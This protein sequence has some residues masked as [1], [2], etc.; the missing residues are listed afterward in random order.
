MI[1][2]LRMENTIEDKLIGSSLER[3]VPNVVRD[4]QRIETDRSGERPQ[5][6]GEQ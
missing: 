3:T 2:L 6:T 5:D 1:H 4:A